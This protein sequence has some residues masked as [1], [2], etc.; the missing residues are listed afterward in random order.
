MG[1]LV[2][3][4]FSLAWGSGKGP[5]NEV[6]LWGVS[7]SIINSRNNVKEIVTVCFT[8]EFKLVI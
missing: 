7:R 3:R 8:K 5:G 1:N 6:G 4:T 2:P